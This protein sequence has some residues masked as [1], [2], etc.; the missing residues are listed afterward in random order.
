MPILNHRYDHIKIYRP[1]GTLYAHGQTMH[2][3]TPAI[4]SALESFQLEFGRPIEGARTT[5]EVIGV[6]GG[7]AATVLEIPE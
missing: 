6:T 7:W 1:K 2:H 4:I 5:I 3:L